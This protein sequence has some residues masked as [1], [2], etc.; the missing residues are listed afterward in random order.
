MRLEN[1]VAVVVG[2]TYGIGRSI[3]AMFAKEGAKVVVSGRTKEKGQN[4][5]EEI[6]RANGHAR[7]IQCD[8][9]Q[10]NQIE[11][12]I[13]GAVGEYGKLDILVNNAFALNPL[14]P[15]AELKIEEWRKVIDIILN[16]TFLGCKYAIPHMIRNGRGSI[17]N[18]GSVG[19]QLGFSLHSAYNAAKAGVANL[20]RALALEYG[21][22][23]IRANV[24]CPGI[25]ATPHTQHEV[26]DPIIVKGFMQKL[27]IKR[28]GCVDD[29]AYAAVY[30]ASDESAYVTGQVFMVDG[31]WTAVGNNESI[32]Y[33]F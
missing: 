31:G 23:N 1:K 10:A 28:I 11:A 5:V 7:F 3:A 33:E 29:I 2:S 30:F 24:I 18:I 21:P 22:R 6:I 4:V 13:D 16:G 12:L 20:S 9:S 32:V 14:K 19:T 27:A 26:D 17:I 15:M 8:V 25:V